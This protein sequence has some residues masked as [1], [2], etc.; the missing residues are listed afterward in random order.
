VAVTIETHITEFTGNVEDRLAESQKIFEATV[1]ELSEN[2]AALEAEL[3]EKSEGLQ[4]EETS[5]TLLTDELNQHKEDLKTLATD[6]AQ[7]VADTDG[8]RGQVARLEKEHKVEIQTLQKESKD[9]LK[10]HAEERARIHKKEIGFWRGQL[11]S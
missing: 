5:N 8:L 10:Q 4:K 2:L 9:F 1:S 11:C 7:L 3:D 6:N